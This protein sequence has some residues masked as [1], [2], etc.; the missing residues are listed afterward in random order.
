MEKHPV[1]TDPGHEHVTPAA[2]RAMGLENQT[3]GRVNLMALAESGMTPDLLETILQQLAG[4]LPR[5]SDPDMA[6]NNFARFV[7][8][9]RN[10]LGLGSLFERDPRALEILLQIFSA[11]QYFSDLIITDPEGYDLLRITEGQPVARPTL[12]DEIW[13]ELVPHDHDME[14]AGNVLRRFKH[15]ESLRVAYGDLIC[16]QRLETVTEQISCLAEA[17]LDAAVRFV[18]RKHLERR[19]IPR[20]P[21]GKPARFSV[22]GMGKLGGMELNYSSDIDL[23]YLYDLEGKTDGIQSQTNEEFFNAVACD[24]IGLLTATTNLGS[25]Y[26]VDL[27]LRPGGAQAPLAISA[28]AAK[29]HYD[30]TGRTWERQAYVKARPVAGD[31]ELGQWFLD[32]LTPWIYR[33]YLSLAEITEIKALKRRIEHLTRSVGEEAYDVKTGH[34]GIRDI[35]FVIQF[36]QLLNGGDLPSVRTGNTLKA[37]AKLSRE[38]C[39]SDQE[40]AI[41]SENY[42]FLRKVEHRLQIMFD[43]QTHR[44]PRDDRERHKLALRMG[45]TSDLRDGPQQ[46]FDREYKKI[47]AENRKML[48]HLL[49][50][51]FGDDAPADPEVD[52]I[53]DPDPA[54]ERVHHLLSQYGFK[55]TA[56]AYRNLMELAREPFRFLSARRCRH[57]L[58]SIAPNLLKEISRLPDPDSTLLNLC[59]VSDSLGGKGVLW[60]L[61]SFS[62]PSLKLYVDLC[63]TSPY[64][65]NILI[66]NPGMIDEL[67]DSLVLDKLPEL[68]DQEATL[69]ELC[70]G[71]EDIDPI[72]HS[73]K[74]AQRLRVGVRD[75]L[76]KEEI[77]A[78]NG[79]LSDIAETCLRQMTRMEYPQLVQKLGEPVV[80]MGPRAGHIAEFVILAMGKFGGRELNYQSD[81]DLIFLYEGQG[82]TQHRRS[83]RKNEGITS[84]QHFFGELAQRIVKTANRMGPFGRL[85][86]IDPRLRP[87]GQSGPLATSLDGFAEYFSEGGG[88]LW[89]RMALCRSRVVLGNEIAST[90]TLDVITTAVYGHSWQQTDT[91]EMIEMRDRLEQSATQSNLKRG[92]GGI[93]DIE[94]VVQMLQLRHGASRPSLRQPNTVAAVLAL[95]EEGFLEDA[96]VQFITRSYRLFRT[97]ESR[98]QLMDLASS[99]ELP[100]GDQLAKL[101]LMLH[102]NEPDTLLEECEYCRQHNR[103]LF[104]RFSEQAASSS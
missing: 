19:G 29:Q 38:G 6:L 71:A 46:A 96:D 57:F 1:G 70:R 52:L 102:Y 3:R 61:F 8:A 85:Y 15:R 82:G 39:L 63:A 40:Q 64:L 99:D 73:F 55:D 81:L 104:E 95:Q 100:G 2:L 49:H 103:R 24:V 50:D 59:R 47:T 78:T 58:A 36:L 90:H 28:E 7:E 98:L 60:E 53:L 43:L 75:I 10:P 21:Q 11:S 48:D 101:A 14:K 17:I 32:Q 77:H 69:F 83:E 79:A 33:R 91:D 67:M 87:T 94:F 74:N 22:L 76:G 9:A 89:E 88:Q 25:L 62:R 65:S 72:L 31:R 54:P 80:A 5:S 42:R 30:L 34:G 26:R 86:E 51:A 66:R 68:R 18:L 56:H 92:R 12:A 20:G 97:I 44:I 84:N 27:R 13:S 23:I 35:E 4:G 16:Q 45:Y 93:V 41:L 37:I